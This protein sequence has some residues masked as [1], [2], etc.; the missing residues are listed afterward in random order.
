[1]TQQLP[2][3]NQYA[4]SQIS[5]QP[6]QQQLY[7]HQ[8]QQQFTQ[9]QLIQQPQQPVP[10]LS[11]HLAPPRQ[12]SQPIVPT[13][14]LPQTPTQINVYQ[15]TSSSQFSQKPLQEPQLLPHQL[16]WYLAEHYLTKASALPT[17]SLVDFPTLSSQ[18]QRH[19]LSAINCLEAVL[20]CIT[21]GKNYMPLVD[22]KTRF[23]LSQIL[24]WFTDNIR[25]AENHIQKAILLAQELDKVTELKFRMIDLQ[26]NI[27]KSA[28]KL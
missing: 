20:K 28:K 25:E 22:L 23:R 10:Q 4:Q 9:Q 14:A 12:L 24:F 11:E 21:T 6:S 8:L 17:S 27:F 5:Q 19:I 18:H 2:Q 16:L 15:Q 1:M 13:Q 7:Q 3:V 26:C